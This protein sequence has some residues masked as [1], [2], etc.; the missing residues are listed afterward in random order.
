MY[1]PSCGTQTSEGLNY[2]K[3]CGANLNPQTLGTEPVRVV[4]SFKLV[5]LFLSI[6]FVGGIVPMGVLTNLWQLKEVGVG[7]NQIATLIAFAA[8]IGLITV[9]LLVWLLLKLVGVAAWEP[10]KE[11]GKRLR[12]SE[13]ASRNQVS[14]GKQ[15]PAP[16]DAI[17]SV[18]ENTTRS[19]D[20]TRVTE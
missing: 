17:P 1:C 18:T 12:T 4:F 8:G 2:C 11:R 5:I 14:V 3:S 16:P 6:A 15:I 7:A 9:A 10:A 20:R 19:F 13:L